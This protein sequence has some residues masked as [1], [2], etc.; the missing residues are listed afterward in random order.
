MSENTTPENPAPEPTP[1]AEPGAAEEQFP[2][3]L[4]R[5]LEA[6]LKEER[7]II[8]ALCLLRP[9]LADDIEALRRISGWGEEQ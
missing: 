6:M 2:K 9:G 7:R 8:A 4:A 1:S 5:S 3:E